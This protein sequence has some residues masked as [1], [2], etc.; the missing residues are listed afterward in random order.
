MVKAKQ[1]VDTYATEQNWTRELIRRGATKLTIDQEFVES[2]V[3]NG[4]VQPRANELGLGSIEKKWPR[5]ADMPCC[6]A[7][8][9]I[10]GALMKLRHQE[11]RKDCPSDLHDQFH[12]A[13]ASMGDAIATCDVRLQRAVK[14]IAWRPLHV[15]GAEEF[16]LAVRTGKL[17]KP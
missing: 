8:V 12:Y 14:F 10:Y 17:R 3:R 6:R 1:E 13:L 2:W 11:N 9:S 15:L 5:A 7:H 4:F 16:A